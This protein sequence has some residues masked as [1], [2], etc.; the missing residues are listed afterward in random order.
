MAMFGPDR[1]VMLKI[2][3]LLDCSRRTGQ[4]LS[5]DTDGF[6]L[7]PLAGSFDGQEPNCLVIRN[8]GNA[9]RVW[10]APLVESNANIG[11]VCDQVGHTYGCWSDYFEKHPVAASC[12]NISCS[13]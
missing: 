12:C 1:T 13:C 6:L 2:A 3:S 9:T 11:Y 4:W 10:N 5:F 8:K 7:P